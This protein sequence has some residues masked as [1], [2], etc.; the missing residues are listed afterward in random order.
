VSPDEWLA[1]TVDHALE[2]EEHYLDE[3][4]LRADWVHEL[5]EM[6]EAGDDDE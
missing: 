1:G 6:R 2:R 5:A 4:A 3:M